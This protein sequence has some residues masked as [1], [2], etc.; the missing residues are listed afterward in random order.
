M[1]EEAGLAY[2]LAPVDT[3]GRFIG[4]VYNRQRL[5]SAPDYLAP[6]VFETIKARPGAAARQPRASA[7]TD[8]H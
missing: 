1:A 6:A 5:R 3:R 8:R 2:E 4:E 7:A